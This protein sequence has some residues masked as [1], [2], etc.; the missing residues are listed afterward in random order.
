MRQEFCRK[1]KFKISGGFFICLFF[2]Q[3]KILKIFSSSAPK[4]LQRRFIIFF[5]LFSL[6]VILFGKLFFDMES[7]N[8]ILYFYGISVS[9]VLL[10]TF[11]FAFFKYSDP[12]L[13]AAAINPEG[14]NNYLVSCMV[15]VKDEEKI[16]EQCILSF[17]KQTY[18]NKEIIFVNDASCDNTEKILDEYAKKKLISVIHLKK[19]IGKKR[20]LGK[21]MLMA[22]G[23]IFV[24]S[25]SDSILAPDAIFKIVKIF[26]AF[27]NIGAVSGHCRA[28]NGNKNFLTKIQ[29]S[30]Y[31]GQFS[32]RKAF[33]SFFGAVSC[34]SGPLAVFRKE[35]IFNYIPAWENDSFLGQEFKFAT[36]RTLT[37]FVLGSNAIG[38]KLKKKVFRFFVC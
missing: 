14:K 20:A 10:I 32:V 11:Y 5:I 38:K 34:V 30:W 37:G 26:K 27:P 2:L 36:D 24:F 12:Y 9:F 18:K 16:I 17:L 33:E 7:P 31:E 21:A 29:D 6:L 3:K 19:N 25:D 1:I 4:N 8:I 15:A 28:L 35:A 13:A 22:K 23:E